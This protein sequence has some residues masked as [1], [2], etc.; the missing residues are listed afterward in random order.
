MLTA[1]FDDDPAWLAVG[2]RSARL[3]R[4]VMDLSHWGELAVAGRFDGHMRVAQRGSAL[5]GLALTYAPGRYPTPWMSEA[6]YLPA[7][8]IAGLPASVRSLRADSIIEAAHP[9]RPHLYLS[10]LAVA[11]EAQRTGVG[12]ALL[13]WVFEQAERLELPVYLEATKA[14][15][16]PYYEGHGFTVTGEAG[17]PGGAR[18]WFMWRERT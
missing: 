8:A 1:A 11:P 18:A 17:L 9:R 2:P 7:L 5:E 4:R 15:N 3:R 13:G 16:V 14:I 12:G 10:L 6:Y